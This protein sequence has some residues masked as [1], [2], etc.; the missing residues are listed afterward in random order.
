MPG[1]K[2][3]YWDKQGNLRVGTTAS[4]PRDPI[5]W[6]EQGIS[7]LLQGEGLMAGEEMISSVQE[8][9][10]IGATVV[11]GDRDFGVSMRRLAD[12]SK[13]ADVRKLFEANRIF[14]KEQVPETL[15][16]SSRASKEDV[17]D[18]V[19][20]LKTKEMVD[21]LMGTWKTYAPE[22]YNVMIEE[23]NEYMSIG[24]DDLSPFQTVVAVMG[25][26]HVDGVTRNLATMGWR[27][28]RQPKC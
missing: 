2:L 6:L 3:G 20:A 9:F 21:K 7:Q 25:L 26:A 8:A 22:A 23:R 27:R 18:F 14:L 28:I 19:E 1:L 4:R 24:L 16:P 5:A 12:A 17:R 10:N 15:M 13:N 11:L